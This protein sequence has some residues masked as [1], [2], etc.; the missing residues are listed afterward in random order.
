MI[1]CVVS[2]TNWR[3]MLECLTA[4]K[5]HVWRTA[6]ILYHSSLSAFGQVLVKA[7]VVLQL[8]VDRLQEVL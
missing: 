6:K 5:M 3:S 7:E 1:D 4:L 8:G 2:L